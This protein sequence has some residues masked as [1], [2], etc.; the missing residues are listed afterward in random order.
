MSQGIHHILVD[1]VSFQGQGAGGV[2]DGELVVR[3]DGLVAGNAREEGFP[4]SGEAC[5]VVGFD[6]AGHNAQ[7][8][9]PGLVAALVRDWLERV[10]A[11]AGWNATA[12][13]TTG[14][15]RPGAA[16]GDPQRS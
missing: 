13:G 5:K 4:S 6:T 16:G 15:T 7:I 2:A 11:E 9:R 12:E 10:G 14:G 3:H 1:G 8:E